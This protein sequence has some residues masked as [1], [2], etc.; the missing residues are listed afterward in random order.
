M[1]LIKAAVGSAG[2]VLADQW[3]EFFYCDSLDNDALAAKGQK[4]VNKKRSSNKKG[5]D[6]IISNGS[7]I[8]V[9][10]GQAMMIVEQGRIVEFCAE[11]GEFTWDS[12]TEPSIFTGDLG[13]GINAAFAK[14]GERMKFGGDT[15]KDQRVYYFNTKEIPGNKFGT[16]SPVPFRIVDSNIGL[17]IDIS[18]RCNGEFSFK[19]VDP[20]AFYANVCGNVADTYKRSEIMGQLKTELLTALQP[21]FAKISEMGVRYSAMPAHTTEICEILDNEL[22]DK[23]TNLRGLQIISFGINSINASEEDEAMIKQLQKS[24]VMRDP[25]MAAASI[26]GAQSDAMKAAAANDAGAMAGFM[27]LGM[28]QAAGGANAADLFAQAAATT[29]RASVAPS[30]SNVEGAAAGAWTCTCGAQNSG[31]FCTECG[32]P[33]PTATKKFCG[34]CGWANPDPANPPKFCPECGAQF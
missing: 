26:V 9:A 24:A 20:L 16:P 3:L 22:A 25:S 32:S 33:K 17:D 5:D 34:N 21:A 6:N 4:R 12:S 14:F 29:P 11:P 31:K 10:D 23:W 15:G 19:V 7:R 1:G 2:G 27:G 13:E 8:A 30:A 18:V 28:A